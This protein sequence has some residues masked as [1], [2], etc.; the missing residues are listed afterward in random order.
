MGVKAEALFKIACLW[1]IGYPSISALISLV[2]AGPIAA[3]E[4]TQF[5]TAFLFALSLMTLT[6]IPLTPFAPVGAGGI[7]I[8]IVIGVLQMALTTVYVPCAPPRSRDRA[9]QLLTTLPYTRV[10]YNI[11]D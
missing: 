8:T 11:Q 4:Q 9:E 5:G 2:L 7:A 6:G 1:L 3:A 10:E